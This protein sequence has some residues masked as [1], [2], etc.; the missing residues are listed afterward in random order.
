MHKPFLFFFL[1]CLFCRSASCQEW[2]WMVPV[3][4]AVSNET[5]ERPRA[6]LWIPPACRQVRGVV[7]GQHNMLEEGI[8]EHPAFRRE[9]ARL[10][11][12][13]IWVSPYFDLTFDF[14]RGAG[15]RFA[16]LLQALTVESGYSELEWA[17][18]VPIGHSALA[19]YPWNFAAWNPGR[20]L[21]VISLKGDA[22][23]TTLT[24]SGRPNPAWGDRNMEGVPGLMV[25]GEYEWGEK[26]L[27][28]ALD[29]Q[30]QYGAAP[31]ALLADAGRGHFDYSDELV[32]YLALFLRKAAKFRL[33]KAVI[34][35]QPPRLQAV[36]PRNGW[37]IDR[38]RGD[39][40][41]QAKAAPYHRYRGNRR[42]AFWCFDEEM[43]RATER[44]YARNR[45]K[46]PQSLVWVQQGKTV[47]RSPS[48]AQ[49]HLQW[50]PQED[51][52]TFSVAV[53]FPDSF[54]HPGKGKISITRICGPVEQVNDTTCRVSFYRMGLNNPKRTGDVWLLASHPGDRR[55]KSAVQQANLRI[56]QKNTG[57]EEQRITFP[58]IDAIKKGTASLALNALSTSGLPVSY[59]VQQGPAEVRNGRLVLTKIPP[60]SRFPIKVTVVAWQYGK[61]GKV[62]T[63]APLE[64]TFFIR[65]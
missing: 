56:P 24:G 1:C 23:L 53:A 61:A 28:P 41:L 18:V 51:G 59:Y 40:A 13:E 46:R 16:A 48:H 50:Q 54:L 36:D 65:D 49:M 14:T 63:A 17:P 2:Q 39:S 33:P 7:V 57:G 15:G 26:R 5:G 4:G 60:R 6:F 21:A 31:I 27:Q 8:L 37:L 47:P 22:P 45:G 62:Q 19:S 38:W 25:M 11:F 64:Q 34:P 35:G 44:H 32:A 3:E 12:A 9:L 10:G 43:A 20:T 55:Y 58:P 52:V 30:E 29:F 42:E